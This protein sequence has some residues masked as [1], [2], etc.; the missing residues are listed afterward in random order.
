MR[1]S[2]N[3]NHSLYYFNVALKLYYLFMLLSEESVS[4]SPVV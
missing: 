3:N 2:K 1:S 4:Y